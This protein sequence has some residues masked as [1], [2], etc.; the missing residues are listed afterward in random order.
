MGLLQDATAAVNELLNN[1]VDVSQTMQTSSM[2]VMSQMSLALGDLDIAGMFDL[3]ELD[4]LEVPTVNLNLPTIS[5]DSTVET[6]VIPTTPTM[7]GFDT[8][9][10]TIPEDSSVDFNITIPEAP[11]ISISSS[12]PQSPGLSTISIPAMPDYTLP[13]VPI[14][15]DIVLPQAPTI[16]IPEFTAVAPSVS[17][18]DLPDIP[19]F[20]YTEE[21]Y[22]SDIGVALF[23]KILDDIAEGGSGL[24]PDIEQAIYDRMLARQRAENERLYREIED[25]YSSTGFELPTG[26]LASRL[27]EVASEISRKN[28]Q[29]SWEVMIKQ[30]E[31]A[32][33]NTHFTIDKAVAIEQMLRDFFNQQET[34]RLEAA[35][36]VALIAVEVFKALVAKIEIALEIYKTEATVYGERLKAKLAEIE[37]YRARID[38]TR[39]AVDV[40]NA[41]VALYNAQLSGVEAIMG[42]YSTQMES[43]K[44]QMEME[45]AKMQVFR[46]EIDAYIATVEVEKVKVAVFG[47]QVEG[48]RAQVELAVA[49]VNKYKAKVE[50]A[51]SKIEAESVKVQVQLETN[52]GNIEIYK[53]QVDVAKMEAEVNISIAQIG[54]EV[55]KG[56]VQQSLAQAEMAI[57]EA[58]LGASYLSAQAQ[59]NVAKG[60]TY[61]ERMK[62][63][64]SSY[65]MMK[66]MLINGYAAQITGY[67][68]IA[69]SAM[70]AINANASLGASSSWGYN[71]SESDDFSI[72]HTYYY[73]G[74]SA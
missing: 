17:A 41:R 62:A 35:R 29:A 51:K 31:L 30:A 65:L 47:A 14:L 44:I 72:E 18:D 53:S 46:A 49:Q 4:D 48:A 61:V 56:K 15:D 60:Q 57:K 24:N 21:Q 68:N 36:Q 25:Q 27:L 67:T 8:I 43:A 9:D 26:A 2:S 12:V 16:D 42:I 50:A 22:Q 38:G 66:D 45:V 52:K 71:E 5:Y 6:P 3:P 32:Q 23:Q 70:T 69:A 37:I 33:T 59:I 73:D 39:A 34:R 28:D 1:A 54:L 20:S 10:A 11:D 64:V 19:A 63:A 58:E 7:L 55:F 13:T 40:Q 74:G